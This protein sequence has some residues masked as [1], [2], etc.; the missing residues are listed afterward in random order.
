[1]IYLPGIPH[2]VRIIGWNPIV[3]PPRPPVSEIIQRALAGVTGNQVDAFSAAM[4]ARVENVIAARR[5]RR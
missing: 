1:M 5:G 4:K 3:P 2:R